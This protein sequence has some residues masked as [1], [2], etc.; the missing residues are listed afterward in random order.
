MKT[1]RRGIT[2][3]FNR[4]SVSP[5]NRERLLYF[6]LSRRRLVDGSEIVTTGLAYTSCATDLRSASGSG[7]LM[8]EPFCFEGE[9]LFVNVNARGKSICRSS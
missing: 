9:Y 3:I 5:H 4:R 1:Q 6:Y 8:T 7:E 2:P